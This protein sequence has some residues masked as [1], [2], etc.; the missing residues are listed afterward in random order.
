MNDKLGYLP[1]YHIDRDE[2]CKIV[3]KTVG[4]ER[5]MDAFC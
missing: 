3:E 4:Y 1:Q 2:L 5:L